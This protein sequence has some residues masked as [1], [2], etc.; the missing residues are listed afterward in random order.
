MKIIIAVPAAALLGWAFG[1]ASVSAQQHTLMPEAAQIAAATAPL[2]EQF[3]DGATVL[4][5]RPGRADLAILREGAGP[6]ICLAADPSQL[7][8]FH[9][10]CYHRSLE[11]FMAR[12]RELRAGGRGAEVDA[13]RNRE[14]EAGTLAMPTAPAALYSLTATPGDVD[15]ETGEIRGGRPLYVIYVPFATAEST[16]LPTTPVPGAPWLMDAGTAKAHIMFV[17]QM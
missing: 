11:P 10:A 7:E 2:P 1:S 3:R 9:V 4:G 15:R 13:V 6:Y 14:A 17:P 12:G 8:R 5:Y 16:G